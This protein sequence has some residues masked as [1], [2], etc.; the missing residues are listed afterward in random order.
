V[1]RAVIMKEGKDNAFSHGV[2]QRA[3]AAGPMARVAFTFDVSRSCPREIVM[4]M[5]IAAN[6]GKCVRFVS[7]LS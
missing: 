5:P 4:A 6:N 7:T 1:S 2:L 3:F